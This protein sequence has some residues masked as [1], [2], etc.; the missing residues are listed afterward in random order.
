MRGNPTNLLFGEAERDSQ[1]DKLLRETRYPV[2]GVQFNA[3]PTDVPSSATPQLDTRQD[4]RSLGTVEWTKFG[5]PT[6][7][8]GVSAD[9][10]G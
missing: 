6:T 3:F 4:A 7:H 5:E 10:L 1:A 9:S 8:S 2:A